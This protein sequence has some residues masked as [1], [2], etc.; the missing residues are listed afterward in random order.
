MYFSHRAQKRF[1][2]IGLSAVGE[3]ANS[4]YIRPIIRQKKF[5]MGKGRNSSFGNCNERKRYS[6]SPFKEK[7]NRSFL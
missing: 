5:G 4:S 3:R 6:S 1:F 7:A 2:R